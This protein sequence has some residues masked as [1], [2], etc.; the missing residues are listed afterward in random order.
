MVY[1]NHSQS[2]VVYDCFTHIILVAISS[3]KWSHPGTLLNHFFRHYKM[4]NRMFGVVLEIGLSGYVL[5][6]FF[7]GKYYF[8]E[9]TWGLTAGKLF[10]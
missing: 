4:E 9:A 2:W 1:I 7:L 3:I 10:I 5:S 6:I 8:I